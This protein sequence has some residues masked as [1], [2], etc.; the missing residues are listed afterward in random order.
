M[1]LNLRNLEFFIGISVH[2]AEESKKMML[3]IAW[4][5]RQIPAV[6]SSHVYRS[7]TKEIADFSF[8]F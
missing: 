8:Q 1:K 6:A 5:A 4:I 3:K 7:W 2:Q